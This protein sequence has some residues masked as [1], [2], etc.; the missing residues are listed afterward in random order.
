MADKLRI[1]FIKDALGVEDVHGAFAGTEWDV[2]AEAPKKGYYF[3]GKTGQMVLALYYEV[4]LIE[5][6][7]A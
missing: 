7:K 6:A 3:R 5:G 4:V 1:R 2:V